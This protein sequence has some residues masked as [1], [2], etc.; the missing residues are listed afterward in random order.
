MRSSKAT[1]GCF[2]SPSHHR[3]RL[4]GDPA[5]AVSVA[6]AAT[7]PCWCRP[8]WLLQLGRAGNTAPAAAS[9]PASPRARGKRSSAPLLLPSDPLAVS[10]VL[11]SF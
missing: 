8:G 6:V 5:V 2:G 10:S 1:S 11:P 9:L 3:P 4:P 7:G